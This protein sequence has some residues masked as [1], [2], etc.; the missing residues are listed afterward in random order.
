MTAT[1]WTNFLASRSMPTAP[2]LSRTIPQPQAR[3]S[4]GAPRPV[5]NVPSQQG[6]ALG[7]QTKNPLAEPTPN[8]GLTGPALPPITKMLNPEMDLYN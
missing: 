1:P 4:Y 7:R 8:M 3:T 5:Q 6:P 2:Q